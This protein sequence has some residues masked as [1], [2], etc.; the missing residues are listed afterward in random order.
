LNDWR[1][2]KYVCCNEDNSF[3]INNIEIY[4]D[5]LSCWHTCKFHK[6]R[7]ENKIY[8][9]V[10]KDFTNTPGGRLRTDSDYSGEEFRE[11]ILI[12][13]LLEAKRNNCYLVIDLDGLHGASASFLNEAFGEL[14]LKN[15]RQYGSE[16]STF[17]FSVYEYLRIISNEMPDYMIEIESF[18]EERW[19]D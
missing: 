19:E 12:P 17:K 1:R 14:I 9:K 5:N 10:S 16:M 6:S 8:V 3:D 18:I 4:R 13:K 15:P 7:S 11:T 2:L